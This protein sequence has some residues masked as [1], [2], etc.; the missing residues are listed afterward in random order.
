MP[1]YREMYAKMMTACEQAIQLV[2]TTQRECEELYVAA[3]E[4]EL[5]MLAQPAKR[6]KD[7]HGEKAGYR[8]P[9]A[10]QK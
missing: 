10:P 9:A 3:P 8:D 5:R 2:I 6:K 7:A 4:G 1:D